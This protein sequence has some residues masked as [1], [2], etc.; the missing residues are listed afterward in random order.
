MN[1]FLPKIIYAILIMVG[2][3][4]NFRDTYAVDSS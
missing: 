4:L 3:V 1:R 2:L